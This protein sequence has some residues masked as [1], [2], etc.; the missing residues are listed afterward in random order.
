M[1]NLRAGNTLT[2]PKGETGS[3]DPPNSNP[4]MFSIRCNS[5]SEKR[6]GTACNSAMPCHA[7]PCVGHALENLVAFVEENLL[8]ASS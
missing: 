5:D 8:A 4:L 1:Q 7:M 6:G 3:K 2:E